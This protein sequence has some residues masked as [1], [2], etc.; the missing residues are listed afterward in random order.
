MWPEA[1]L[2]SD[3]RVGLVRCF[4]VAPLRRRLSADIEPANS[5]CDFLIL[6]LEET[7]SVEIAFDK[8][9][10]KIL[11]VKHPNCLRQAEFFHPMHACNTLNTAASATQP[12]PVRARAARHEVYYRAH[13]GEIDK[14]R[15]R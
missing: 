14:V 12:H 1:T 3:D 13:R 6:T 7:G 9:G 4:A 5:G 15:M 2:I 11:D 10:S 8:E